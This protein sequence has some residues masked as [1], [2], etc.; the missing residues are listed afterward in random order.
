[1]GE[2]LLHFVE[3]AEHQPDC[4]QELPYFVAEIKRVFHPRRGR[5][6]RVDIEGT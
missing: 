3:A 6:L 1:M 2:K 4:V 5:K